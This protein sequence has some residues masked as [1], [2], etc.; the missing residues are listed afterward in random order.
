[1]K[2]YW[3]DIQVD[4]NVYVGTWTARNKA[5][6]KNQAFNFYKDRAREVCKVIKI[7]EAK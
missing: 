3:I 2:N 5:D 4:D 7:T 6:A 1:M